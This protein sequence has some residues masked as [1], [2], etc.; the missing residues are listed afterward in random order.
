M[1]SNNYVSILV[2]HCVFIEFGV[3][4]SY[5]RHSKLGLITK[6]MISNSSVSA[7]YN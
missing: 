1:I 3:F 5:R 7:V 6:N 2:L 4:G